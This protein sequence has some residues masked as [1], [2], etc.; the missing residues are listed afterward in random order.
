MAPDAEPV[1]GG[2]S[3]SSCLLF[4]FLVNLAMLRSSPCCALAISRSGDWPPLVGLR[5]PLVDCPQG[6][7]LLAATARLRTF[8]VL[9]PPRRCSGEA[10]LRQGRL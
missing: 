5:L 4:S 8:L 7:Q 3:P 10:P 9:L 1:G 2:C 6:V